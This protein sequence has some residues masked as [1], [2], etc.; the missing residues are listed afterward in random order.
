MGM[1]CKPTNMRGLLMFDRHFPVWPPGVPQTLDLPEQ[2]LPQN[3]ANSATRHPDQA[4]II[5]YG[6][7]LTYAQLHE[8]VEALA[9][10]LQHH[11]GVV[12]GDRVLLY[13]Q[14]SP[15]FVISY[16]AILRADAVVI[17]VNPMSRHAELIHYATDAG[18]QVMLTGQELLAHAAPLLEDDHLQTII[19]A[20]YAQ[21]A[22]PGSD[23][24]LPAP[25][26]NQ[27]PSDICGPGIVRW[28]DAL[29]C[30]LPPDPLQA[31]P[32]DL[33]V[34]PYSSGTTGQPK[35]C[36]HTHR[37]VQVTCIGG[38]V[39]NP[40]SHTDI[41]LTVLPMF[42]VVGMQAALN[43]PIYAGGTMVIMTRWDRAAAARLIERHRVT[44][45]RSIATMAI[46]LVND[47]E[48]DSYDLSSLKAIGGGG[49]AMPEAIAK[50]LKDLTGLDYV[51]GYGMSETMAATHINPTNAPKRQCLG[52]PVFDVDCRVLNVSDGTQLGPNEVGELVMSGPQVFKGYWRNET[53]TNEALFQMEGKTFIHSGDLG[54]Y[55][56]DGYFFMIDR[57]KRMIN[58]GGF[59]IWPAE[60]EALMHKHPRIAE[61]CII[62][63]P[64]VRRGESVKAVVV[65]QPGEAPS[66]ED[67][68]AWCHN[69]MA[70]YKCPRVVQFAP[71]LPKSGSGKVLWRELQQQENAGA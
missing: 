7:S 45:W 24:S 67:I 49:A 28:A 60:V 64:D 3:L 14:N 36:M 42:H 62:S 70:A 25:L 31:T 41:S 4:A 68:I 23:I 55:D 69:E 15:Q 13:M 54:Y 48:F 44:R 50:K 1:H 51:E 43:G 40:M 26:S 35:G 20:T 71:S 63:T 32:D 16:Y 12:Q 57:I 6:R 34:I 5:Y 27:D 29:A 65:P 39:W 11:A 8:Q 38:V 53:A 47:P 33:A 19:A 21:M 2:T 18:A 61:V 66:S 30:Q 52:V 22:D 9:G 56:E 10:Y 58:A 59:K 17:P 37:T 46:D